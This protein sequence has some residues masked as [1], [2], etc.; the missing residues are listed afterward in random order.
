MLL[1]YLDSTDF[2][3]AALARLEWGY[4]P[5]LED[6]RRPRILYAALADDPD[7]FVDLVALVFRGKNE[8][9][10]E[11]DEETAALARHA[12][13]VL[14]DW[15]RPPGLSDDGRTIDLD[16]LRSWVRRARQK[17]ADM[18]RAHI[19]DQQ[20]GHLLSGSPPGADDAWPAE[21][22]R[23]IVEDLVSTHLESGLRT[24]RYNA[25]GVTSRGVYEGGDQE[26]KLA[27]RY[28]SWARTIEDRWPRTA[29]IL[30]DLAEG[31]ESEARMN[32]AEAERQATEG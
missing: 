11:V 25:R 4:F 13:S 16:R 1:D 2:D 30:D 12:Y 32:D 6:Q 26:R 20:I 7:L 23:E 19:G 27:A 9:P 10:R 21:P 15:R 18:D 24:G 28:I 29:R 5:L 31:Y 8:P 3:K 17:L 14:H 22:V